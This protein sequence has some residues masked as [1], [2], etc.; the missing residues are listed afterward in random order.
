[1]FRHSLYWFLAL[2][3]HIRLRLLGLGWVKCS[4]SIPPHL[5]SLML[6]SSCCCGVFQNPTPAFINWTMFW[7]RV[8]LHLSKWILTEIAFSISIA[9]MIIMRLTDGILSKSSLN[10]NRYTMC[11]TN[12]IVSRQSLASSSEQFA[13][14]WLNIM[15]S[16]VILIGLLLFVPLASFIICSILVH[17]SLFWWTGSESNGVVIP[18]FYSV[19]LVYYLVGTLT[20]DTRV[21]RTSVKLE[22]FPESRAIRRY[23]CYDGVMN[24]GITEQ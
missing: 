3:C 1:M 23:T 16:L 12:M 15:L 5:P 2:S 7:N 4:L 9:R 14:R 8:E 22:A 24:R 6:L 18:L 10:L 13:G 11:L 19:D 20:L 21:E 17:L